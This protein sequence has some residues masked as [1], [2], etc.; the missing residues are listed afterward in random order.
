MHL[1]NCVLALEV[2]VCVC[3]Y[4]IVFNCVLVMDVRVCVCVCACLCVSAY[5]MCAWRELPCIQ[6][7]P[8]VLLVVRVGVRGGN[9]W[10][11]LPVPES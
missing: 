2:C 7:T 10:R 6:P 9:A 1:F 3:A 11:V 4:Y 5:Y 8:L